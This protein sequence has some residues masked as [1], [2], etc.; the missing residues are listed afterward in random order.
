MEAKARQTNIKMTARKLRRVINEVRGKAVNDA[1]DMLRF[2]PYF[3]ARVVEKNLKAAAAN[4]FEQAG[5]K[6]DAL[7]VSEIFADES[8]TYKRGKPR[9]QGRIY[10]RLK[11]T[12][13]LTI[14]VSDAVK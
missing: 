2:M 7:K 3:A 1:L 8:V 6:S 13:H 4:A 14:K 10:R 5:V 11:R 9:A 12:S